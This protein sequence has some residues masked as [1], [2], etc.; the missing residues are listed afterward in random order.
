MA[1]PILISSKLLFISFL[2]TIAV[3][4]LTV[5]F[6]GLD[7]KRSI[8][9]NTFITLTILSGSFFCFLTAGLYY[10]IKMKQTMK[11]KLNNEV[12]V[13]TVPAEAPDMNFD[14]PEMG[15]GIEGALLS[16][17]FWVAVTFGTVAFLFFFETILYGGFIVIVAALYWIFYRA[18]R[19]VLKQSILCKG[20]LTA[21]VKTGFI[22]TLLYSGWIYLIVYGFYIL[23]K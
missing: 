4:S 19:L 16:L 8:Y 9:E 22:Y 10:G 14:V 23:K 17:L 13:S 12:K 7:I 5:F 2:I 15:D 1:R 20:D 6:T 11:V 21:A 3:T 18:L